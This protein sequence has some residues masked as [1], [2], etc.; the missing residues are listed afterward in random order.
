MQNRTQ[1]RTMRNSPHSIKQVIGIIE[2]KIR[3][4]P[5]CT[6]EINIWLEITHC[7]LQNNNKQI[8]KNNPEYYWKSNTSRNNPACI[9]KVRGSLHNQTQELEIIQR[10]LKK[11]SMAPCTIARNTSAWHNTHSKH[12]RPHCV[13]GVF[14]MDE[15]SLSRDC[16]PFESD[17]EEE[18]TDGQSTRVRSLVHE[19]EPSVHKFRF[20]LQAHWARRRQR[21]HG[22]WPWATTACTHHGTPTQWRWPARCPSL[23]LYGGAKGG[24]QRQGKATAENG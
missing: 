9:K 13:L 23:C 6:I 20:V 19:H 4:L 1:A 11:K 14:Y 21:P 5:P 8:N 10:V 16:E 18:S 17:G 2:Y 24:G 12:E 22:A 7:T 3:S 15:D